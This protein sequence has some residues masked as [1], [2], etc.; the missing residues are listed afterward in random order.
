MIYQIKLQK[1]QRNNSQLLEIISQ[2][3]LITNDNLSEVSQQDYEDI[4]EYEKRHSVQK[5]VKK[6]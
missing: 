2:K 4:M 5:K 3:S 6:L 1:K